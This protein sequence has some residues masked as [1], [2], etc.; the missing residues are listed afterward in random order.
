MLTDEEL[1]GTCVYGK[2]NSNYTKLL[3]GVAYDESGQLKEEKNYELGEVSRFTYDSG[4]NVTEKKRFRIENGRVS[5]TPYQTDTYDYEAGSGQN[6]AWKDQ[7]KSY[8]GQTIEYD[9]AGNPTSY[10]GKA[11]TWKGRKLM[12]IAGL[13]MEYDYKGYRIKK[14]N[15]RYI[16]Q[17]DRLIAEIEVMRERKVSS[18]TITTK[19]A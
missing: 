17:E 11:L 12:G 13:G 14:G 6:G 16:W 10:L 9:G 18:I 1:T 3:Q 19:A 7:L 5:N 2:I 4:N 8:N 15:K